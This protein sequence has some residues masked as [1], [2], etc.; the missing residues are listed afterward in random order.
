[1]G[2]KNIRSLF[3]EDSSGNLHEITN[4]DSFPNICVEH[5]PHDDGVVINAFVLDDDI[6]Y[7]VPLAFIKNN[8]LKMHGKP[9][10]RKSTRRKQKYVTGSYRLRH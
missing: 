1:M 5:T 2:E 7:G 3:V 4:S 8:Y 9:M 10:I 6:T